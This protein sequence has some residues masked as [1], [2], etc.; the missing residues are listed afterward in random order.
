M[1]KGSGKSAIIIGFDR[2]EP[3]LRLLKCPTGGFNPSALEFI[4]YDASLFHNSKEQQILHENMSKIKEIATGFENIYLVLPDYCVAVDIVNTPNLSRFKIAGALKVES[5]GM[6]SNYNDLDIHYFQVSSN[7]SYSTY[8]SVIVHK[9]LLTE[10]KKLFANEKISLTGITYAS[11]SALNCALAANNKN[12]GKSFLFV[13]INE[14]DTQIVVSSKGKTAG[15]SNLPFGYSIIASETVVNEQ[16]LWN[17]DVAEL[18][19]INAQETAKAKKLTV[20]VSENEQKTEDGSVDA[21][22][23]PIEDAPYLNK[24]DGAEYGL[25][26]EEIEQ[27]RLEEEKIR[28]AEQLSIAAKT[29]VFT[30]KA[31][32]KLPK[33]MQRPEP[34]NEEEM[35]EENFRSILKRILLYNEFNQQ[36]KNLNDFEYVLL[37]IPE[38]FAF[39]VDRLSNDEQNKVTF[40]RVDPSVFA[41]SVGALDL[42]GALY[43]KSY[44]T[45]N[46]F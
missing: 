28:Q 32:K 43:M 2:R 41:D 4:D 22:E 46:N 31:P 7:K 18:A 1:A 13:D 30:R 35:V 25:T 29:K 37:N 16:T 14:N 33:F 6:Y 8:A 44:N 12:K 10:I 42:A 9:T 26:E 19:V 23:E 5:E 38:R 20:A 17:H 11:N 24:D 15:F 34:Q 3:K 27:Q 39:L 40:R 36:N 45:E 21:E